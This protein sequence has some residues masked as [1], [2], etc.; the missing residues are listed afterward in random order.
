[1]NLDP[2]E[3]PFLCWQDPNLEILVFFEGKYF[4]TKKSEK[5]PKNG[6][7]RVFCHFSAKKGW[8]IHLELL[9]VLQSQGKKHFVLFYKDLSIELLPNLGGDITKI[10]K[11][12]NFSQF[13][14]KNVLCLSH[15]CIEKNMVCLPCFFLIF[16]SVIKKYIFILL[17]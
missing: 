17:T 2:S 4:W 3:G 6:H 13:S 1:M 11:K 7:F 16:W 10:V 5:R 14:Y 9:I 12:V 15:F 8:K